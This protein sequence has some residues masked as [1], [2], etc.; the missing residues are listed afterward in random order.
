MVRLKAKNVYDGGW[1]FD[2]SIPYGAIKSSSQILNIDFEGQRI[3][4]PYGAIK[5]DYLVTHYPRALISIP[6]GAIKSNKLFL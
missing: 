2:I 1:N 5:S 3:S 4:I 6:Y